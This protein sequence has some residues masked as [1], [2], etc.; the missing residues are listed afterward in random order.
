[1]NSVTRIEV[2]DE[3]GRVYARWNVVIHQ[4]YQD[5]GRTL[6]VFVKEREKETKDET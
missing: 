3:T 1:M 4:S 5:E 2:I 6:K